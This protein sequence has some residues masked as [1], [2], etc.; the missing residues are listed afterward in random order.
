MKQ[1]CTCKLFQ[2]LWSSK[3]NSNFATLH[4]YIVKTGF[5]AI[6]NDR[7]TKTKFE[8]TLLFSTY[9]T[10]NYIQVQRDIAH[11]FLLA[12]EPRVWSH[13][14]DFDVFKSKE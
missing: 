11:L 8:W 6:N 10:F 3:S 1:N 2:I 4:L 9:T 14:R 7:K 13:R 5:A 12:L